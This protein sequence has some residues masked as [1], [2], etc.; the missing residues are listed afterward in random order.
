MIVVSVLS[1]CAGQTSYNKHNKGNEQIP[2]ASY[3]PS[4]VYEAEDNRSAREVI[5]NYGIHKDSKAIIAKISNPTNKSMSYN[6]LTLE[7]DMRSPA[8]VC[9]MKQ[10]HPV[11]VPSKTYMEI[12]LMPSSMVKKCFRLR[13][14]YSFV[15]MDGQYSPKRGHNTTSSTTEARLRVVENYTWKGFTHSNSNHLYLHFDHGEQPLE[16]WGVSAQG[17]R[18]IN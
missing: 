12:S 9:E 17:V 2:V 18:N 4:V 7:P 1:G 5:I 15:S 11:I 13:I 8:K 16:I 3:I 10:A 14:G 6:N